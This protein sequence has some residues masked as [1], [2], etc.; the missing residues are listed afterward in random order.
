MTNRKV[1]LV[2][3]CKTENG[4]RRYPVVVG[5]NG[6]VRPNYVF[7]D[8]KERAYPEGRY[9]LR[10]YEGSKMV[11]RDAGDNAAAAAT[12]Q[13]KATHVL[14]AKAEAKAGGVKVEED[15]PGRKSLSRGLKRFIEAT[16]DRGSHAAA[17]E[18]KPV[19]ED[20]LRVIGKTYADELTPEDILNFQKD[21]RDR[22][23]SPRTIFNRH[24]YVVAFLKHLGLD[25]KSLAPKRPKF[26]KKLPEVYS[27]GELAAFFASVKDER[28]R[29][30]FELLLKTG[31]R[32]LEAVYLYWSNIDLK[33]GVLRVRSKPQLGFKIKDYEERD[34]PIPADLLARLNTYRKKH[35][36]AKF[37]TGTKTDRPNKK[38]LRTLKRLV[39]AGGLNCGQCRGCIEHRECHHWWLHKFR[40]TCIT[41]LLRSGMDL[42]TVMKFSGHNDLASVMRYLSPAGDEAIKAHVNAVKWM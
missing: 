37:V 42:R 15:P 36:S 14:T 12:A 23:K 40:A 3:L 1:T 11:Y 32:E 17:V 7:V 33:D 35:P 38:L 27:P 25:T 29:L 2:R 20:F 26:E 16:E 22:G 34:I 41:Q 18:Y 9:Q 13:I 39:N 4:W 10:T 5:K 24:G 28:L 8:G 6:R 21:L 31:L 30:T 19:C